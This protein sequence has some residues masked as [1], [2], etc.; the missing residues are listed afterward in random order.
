M[1]FVLKK[2]PSVASIA[3]RQEVSIDGGVDIEI[4]HFKH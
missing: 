3:S 2:E 4:D 1:E